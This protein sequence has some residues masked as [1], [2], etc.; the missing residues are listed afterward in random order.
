VFI[1]GQFAL[2]S[3]GWM[4][5]IV[6]SRS[7]DIGAMAA[8]AAHTFLY[9]PGRWT[10]TGEYLDSEGTAVAAQ[11]ETVIEHGAERWTIVGTLRLLTP[12][13]T[14]FSN[15]CEVAPGPADAACLAWHS[16]SPTFGKL[17]GW[18]VPVGATLLSRFQS[19]SGE[20]EGVEAM[21]RQAADRYAARGCLVIDGA[22][23]SRWELKLE[24]Q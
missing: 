14:D 18:Y 16:E 9:A 24:R 23:A 7:K 1:G 8:K 15:T 6:G 5:L 17:R 4:T 11:G 19:E 22:P 20:L 13:P 3:R 10:V 2:A 21:V 12:E